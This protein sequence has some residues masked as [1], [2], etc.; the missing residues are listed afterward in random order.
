MIYIISLLLSWLPYGIQNLCIAV[1][2]LFFAWSIVRL[3]SHIFDA[4]PF[5]KKL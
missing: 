4:L 1:V 3:L 5:F 2:V